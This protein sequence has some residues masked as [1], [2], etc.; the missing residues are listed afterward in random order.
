MSHWPLLPSQFFL[1]L[2]HLLPNVECSWPRLHT[3]PDEEHSQRHDGIG[4]DWHS[5]D[6]CGRMRLAASLA[7]DM[8]DLTE[9]TAAALGGGGAA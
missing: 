1:D 2:W 8:L 4:E 5:E 3:E 9:V 6:W 7:L